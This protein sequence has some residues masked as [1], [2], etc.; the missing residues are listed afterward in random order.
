M[1]SDDIIDTITEIGQ[2]TL[3]YDFVVT[4]EPHEGQTLAVIQFDEDRFDFLPITLF[5]KE[6]SEALPGAK[7]MGPT[8]LENKQIRILI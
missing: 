3:P 7:L 8:L 2:R 1:T 5:L 4:T 6:S